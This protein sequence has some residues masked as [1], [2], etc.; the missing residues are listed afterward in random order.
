MAFDFSKLRGRI[1]EKY[2][3]CAAFAAD[4]GLPESGLSNRLNNRV[5]IDSDEIIQWSRPDKLDIPAEDIH[6]FFL[7]PKV[8]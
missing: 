8:R 3:T 2:G 1:I 5:M 4:V 6:I 7:T